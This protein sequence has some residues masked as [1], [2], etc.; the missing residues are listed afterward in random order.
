VVGVQNTYLSD[1]L[2]DYRGRVYIAPLSVDNHTLL[3]RNHTQWERTL[4]SFRGGR[5]DFWQVFRQAWRLP[6]LIPVKE[7]FDNLF[8]SELVAALLKSVKILPAWV[9]ASET[10]PSD[11]ARF[12]LYRKALLQV[13]GKRRTVKGYNS[14]NPW[15]TKGKAA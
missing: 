4:E 3:S 6:R 5:Y 10:T 13:S 8:C 11:L 2:R 7:D 14:H 15:L 9:N 1:R 12:D